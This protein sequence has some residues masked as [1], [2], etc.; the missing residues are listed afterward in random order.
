MQIRVEKVRSTET[1]I[2]AVLPAT[3]IPPINSRVVATAPFAGTITR[4]HV[5]PG[6]PVTKGMALITISSRDLLEVQS[7]RAQA[8]A[9]LQMADAIARRK[10]TL[11]DKNYQSP[12]VAEEAEA[13]VAKIKAV[14]E[15]HK[16]TQALGGIIAASGGEYTIPAAADGRVSA[17]SVMPGEKLDAMTAAVAID[18][19]DKI[20]VEA[21]VPSTM[22]PEVRIGDAIKVHGGPEGRVLSIGRSLDAKTRSAM[23][24]AELPA[25]SGL[26]PGQMVSLDVLRSTEARGFSVPAAAVARIDNQ[27]AVFVRSD[28]GFTLTPVEL[29]GKSP[30]VA[31]VTG[32]IT[33]ETT[34]AASGLPA[35]EQMLAGE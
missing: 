27:H 14:I 32:D 17:L 25:D 20:W 13:Q 16:R 33:S 19:S 26:L 8:E 23:L 10:R 9:E 11:A 1:E 5:L 30:D 3:V 22:V 34:V 7:Q 18:T 28:T 2:L 35:L 15:Q 4:V 21:Q 24:F 31:T 6:Q 29:R 12:T